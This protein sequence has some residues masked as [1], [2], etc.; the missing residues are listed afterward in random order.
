M[1]LFD[2]LFFD[3]NLFFN[4]KDSIDFLRKLVNEIGIYI[5]NRNLKFAFITNR[6]WNLNDVKILRASIAEV[7]YLVSNAKVVISFDGGF[8]HIASAFNVLVICLFSNR[9]FYFDS[10]R[11]RYF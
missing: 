1:E 2:I 10:Y 3:K 6:D 7:L 9:Y 4:N 11:F 8:V 5:K